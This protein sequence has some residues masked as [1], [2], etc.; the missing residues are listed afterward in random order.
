MPDSTKT[1]RRPAFTLVELLVVI[2]IIGVLVALL[3]PAVQAAR[4]AARRMQCT[5]NLKQFGLAIHNYASANNEHFPIGSHLNGRHGVFTWML[6]YIEQQAVYDQIDTK[7]PGSGSSMR[8]TPIA[9]YYC[10]SCSYQKVYLSPQ[11]DY[12]RGALTNYQAVGGALVNRGEKI[13]T[14][15]YGNLPNNGMFVLDH[16]RTMGECRD[17]LS[18]SLAFGEFVHRDYTVSA[19][20]AQP[21][22]SVRPWILGENGAKASYAFKVC[23]FAINAPVNRNDNSV[24]FNHLPFGSFHSGGAN[25]CFGDGSVHFLTQTINFSLYESLAT[26]N[27]QE[28]VSPP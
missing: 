15:T 13:T 6:P 25:F 11:Y 26:V 16:V 27:G 7:Q 18:N 4:E 8:N 20:Y 14:S 24:P 28:P 19:S 9:A 22:G 23:E 1:T 3:L 2:A 17:G 10:P 12:Q 5:N 21:P